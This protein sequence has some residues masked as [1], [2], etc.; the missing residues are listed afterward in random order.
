M[1]VLDDILIKVDELKRLGHS[2]FDQLRM[3]WEA[4]QEGKM[5]EDDYHAWT[6]EFFPE[7]E[8]ADTAK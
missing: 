3:F 6:D 1:A 7:T 2:R 5:S 8:R 4:Y